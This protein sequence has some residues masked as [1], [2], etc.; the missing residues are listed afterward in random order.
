MESKKKWYKRTRL[1]NRKCLRDLGNSLWLPSGRM[2]E[3]IVTEFGVDVYTLL[4]WKWITN[5][6]PLHS[7]VNSAQCSVAA[8]MGG[9]SGG[10]WIHVE[11]SPLTVHLK[12]SQHCWL[13]GYIPIQNKKLRKT[14]S[15]KNWCRLTLLKW[16]GCIEW[17]RPLPKGIGNSLVSVTAILMRLGSQPWTPLSTIFFFSHEKLRWERVFEEISLLPFAFIR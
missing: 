4:C 12:L 10:E 13:T 5:K 6:D 17:C 16:W 2:G 9:E 1:P 15:Q 7:T 8:W 11:L 14:S 3:G